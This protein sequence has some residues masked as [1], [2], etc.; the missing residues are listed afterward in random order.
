MATPTKGNVNADSTIV[1]RE[2]LQPMQLVSAS[3]WPKGLFAG[4]DSLSTTGFYGF[5]QNLGNTVIPDAINGL[6][7]NPNHL[8]S[9]PNWFGIQ[10]ALQVSH[11]GQLMWGV[12]VFNPSDSGEYLARFVNGPTILPITLDLSD[13]S[14]VWFEADASGLMQCTITQTFSDK[15]LWQGQYQFAPSYIGPIYTSVTTI[16]G[17]GD[18]SFTN[19]SSFPG[20]EIVTEVDPGSSDDLTTYGLPGYSNA[21]PPALPLFYTG[22]GANINAEVTVDVTDQVTEQYTLGSWENYLTLDSA[23]SLIR[24][25]K[26][27]LDSWVKTTDHTG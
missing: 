3:I 15:Q 12:L 8:P 9:Q 7:T 22:E 17:Y 13:G 6:L 18:G 2:S 16:A 26:R 23:R 27:G 25:R 20:A 21:P 10:Q 5:Q 14:L 11:S 1:Y 4:S 24:P 19:F